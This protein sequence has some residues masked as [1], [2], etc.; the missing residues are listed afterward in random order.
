MRYLPERDPAH[1][2]IRASHQDVTAY[3]LGPSRD[4]ADLKRMNPPATAAWL[5]LD[6]AGQAGTVGSEPLFAAAFTQP[7]SAVGVAR[8]A[9][10][11]TLR[12]ASIDDDDD[13]L[14]AAA[15]VL[16]S[17]VNNT[18]VFLVL[19]V[20]GTRLVFP[21][22]AQQG[23][24]E[25]VLDDP[26]SRALVAD[27]AFYKIGHHGSHNAT[28]RRYVEEVLRDGAETMLPY[29]LVKLW[30]STI[31]KTA[32]LDALMAHG[33]RVTRADGP[34]P[35]ADTVTVNGDLWSQVT[36]KTG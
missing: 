3:A 1:N 9:V 6:G 17:S 7:R 13:A 14:L 18:S 25:H 24:W 19:D 10:L 27:A 36:L 29:G 11:K 21:G 12:L 35:V 33:H 15:S 34:T 28:P 22:D 20:A 31:P 8:R 32:L 2:V 5:R 16:E 23:A 4:P 26:E 30:Q